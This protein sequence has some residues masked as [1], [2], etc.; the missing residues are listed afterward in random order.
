PAGAPVG[1]PPPKHGPLHRGKQRRGGGGGVPGGGRGG[2][3]A[4]PAT[5]AGRLRQALR[6][7]DRGEMESLAGDA[8]REV[9]QQAG[10]G[11]LEY[12]E[13]LRRVKVSLDWAG[14]IDRLE[15]EGGE[16]QRFL[17]A[18]EIVRQFE[19]IIIDRLDG[20]LWRAAPGARQEAAGRADLAG[21]DFG[22]LN[23]EQVEEIKKAVAR[24]ARSLA[25]RLSYRRA[26]YRKGEVDLRRTA[27]CAARTGGIPLVLH[28][29]ARV[30]HRPDLVV[31]CDL[32]GSVSLFT[33]FML[34]LI[35]AV[36]EKFTRVRTFAFV[37][38]V[39]E[40]T[41]L[42][43]EMEPGEAIVRVIREARV[44]RTPFS[45]YG[46]VWREF[47][48]KYNDSVTPRTTVLVLGD[49]RNNWKPPGLEYLG[50]IRERAA[51]IIWLNPAPRERWDRDDSIISL[52]AP[53]CHRLIECRNLKQLREAAR[54]IG[55]I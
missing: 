45:D 20:E 25:A 26:R 51:R 7:G 3:G 42:L 13:L 39:E 1:A 38:D 49:A 24:M 31:L 50:Q 55:R 44:A 12:Q 32:S 33:G 48:R 29:R 23:L 27:R 43:K 40:V 18:R 5:P 19:A 28:R 17:Y 11:P 54:Y 4:A 10:N 14:V 6:T 9:L 22:R 30:P 36:Q 47:C 41:E 34:Q 8:V 52:Y 37:D 16:G 2:G 53:Y 15:K 35:Y 21:V 46:A